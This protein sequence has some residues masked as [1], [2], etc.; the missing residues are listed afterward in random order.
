MLLKN[1]PSINNRIIL[2]AIFVVCA[3]MFLT[4]YTLNKAFYDSA[5]SALEERLTAQVYLLMADRELHPS[6]L[7]SAPQELSVNLLH[8]TYS[9]LSGFV[10]ESDGTILW[11]S[12]DSDKA[13][14]PPIKTITHGKKLFQQF[15]VNDK[16]YIGLS[17]AIFWDLKNQK[18]P[19]VYHITDDLTDLQQR[20]TRYQHDLFSNL[21]VMSIILLFTLVFLLRWGLKPLR[22]VEQE[23]K[24]VEQGQQ[25]L[26]EQSYPVELTPLTHNINQLIHFERQQQQRYRH[27]LDD[28]AHSLKTPLAIIKSQ[29]FNSGQ[30]EK[31]FN[32]VNDAVQRMNAIVEY[33]L[34]RATTSS[35]SSHI[36]YLQL[37]PIVSSMIESMKK[38]YRDKAIHYDIH[39]DPDIEYKMDEG[40]F[41]EILGNLLDNACKWCKDRIALS[42][43]SRNN[44]LAMTIVDNGPGIAKDKI[45]AITARGFRADQLTPGHGVG[46]AIVVDIVHAYNGHIEFI[47]N[48]P[49]GLEVKLLFQL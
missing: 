49:Q 34:Q 15:T 31:Y 19:L 42:I 21:I 40:D 33:Q 22:E 18:Y 4:A 16:S 5:Y 46:L 35:I 13:L 25:N 41:M 28:L 26:I 37:T 38:I 3:F 11:K 30:P 6:G 29:Q 10:T 39:L 44:T 23:I 20:L 1:K 45:S 12:S 24:A 43:T 27:A 17:I 47:S 7:Q 2:G 14:V 9:T 32:S 36:Q 8:N 48:K